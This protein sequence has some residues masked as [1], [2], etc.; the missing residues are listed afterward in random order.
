[1]NIMSISHIRIMVMLHIYARNI[2]VIVVGNGHSETNSNPQR[3]CL[4]FT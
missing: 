3:G 4:L 1:M 2:M